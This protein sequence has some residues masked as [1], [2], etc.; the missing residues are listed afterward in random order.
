MD[1]KTWIE[2]QFEEHR[3]RLHAVAYR[4]LG[5]LS[6]ADDAMQE[7]WL[8][9]T[10]ADTNDIEN[11]GGWLTTVTARVCLTMLRSGNTRREESLDT[12]VPDP[13]VT[14]DDPEQGA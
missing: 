12:H 10:R 9:V 4:M 8:R 13:I 3:Q 5:S 7:T 6:D 11:P 14:V 2:R 1:D